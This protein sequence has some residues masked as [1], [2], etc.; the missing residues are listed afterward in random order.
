MNVGHKKGNLTSLRDIKPGDLCVFDPPNNINSNTN[1]WYM[2]EYPF[3]DKRI[4]MVG[5]FDSW[6]T[7]VIIAIAPSG[8][9]HTTNDGIIVFVHGHIG[10]MLPGQMRRLK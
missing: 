3:T 10:V 2:F 6:E 8:L 9:G 4:R 5:P 1:V 7:A